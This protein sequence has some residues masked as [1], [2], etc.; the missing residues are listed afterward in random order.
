MIQGILKKGA[1]SV[2]VII[3]ESKLGSSSSN[4]GLGCVYFT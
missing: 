2:M 3:I 1:Y 4:P